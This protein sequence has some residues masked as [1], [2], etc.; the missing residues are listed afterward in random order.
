LAKAITLAWPVTSRSIRKVAGNPSG[1]LVRG[2]EED[3]CPALTRDDD[4]R[5]GGAGRDAALTAD[6]DELRADLVDAVETALG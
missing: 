1:F 2:R 4:D 5:Y 6:D 3:S